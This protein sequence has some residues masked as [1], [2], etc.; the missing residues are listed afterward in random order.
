MTSPVSTLVLGPTIEFVTWFT[1][2][3]SICACRGR[4]YSDKTLMRNALAYSLAAATGQYAPRTKFCEVVLNGQYEGVYL[5]VEK[6]KRDKHR[7]D[8]QKFHAGATP[9]ET[10]FIVKIDKNTGSQSYH[11]RGL[12]VHRDGDQRSGWRPA[13][14]HCDYPKSEDLSQDMQRYIQDYITEFEQRLS[15]PGMA[16]NS[17]RWCETKSGWIDYIDVPSFVDYMIVQELVR[18]PGC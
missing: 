6:I 11:W 12:L 14:L 9:E 10:G 5:L 15:E 1:L 2:A 4:Q 13:A 7:V 16:P 18:L 8:V 17:C 3:C